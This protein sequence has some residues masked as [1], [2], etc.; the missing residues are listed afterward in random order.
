MGNIGSQNDLK[1]FAKDADLLIC[2][3]TFLK[4]QTK[5]ADSHLFTYEAANIA[6]KANVNELLLTHFWLDADKSEYVDEAK[7]IFENTSFAEE[8]K[9]MVL[10]PR[11]G[12]R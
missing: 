7:E 2:E 4:N 3:S 6:R 9:K 10:K 8:E 5:S 11:K 1:I 12:V